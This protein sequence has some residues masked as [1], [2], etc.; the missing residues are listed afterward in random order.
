MS[1]NNEN[2]QIENAL[3]EDI[4]VEASAPAEEQTQVEELPTIEPAKVEEI[5]PEP[6]KV[7]SAPAKT[8]VIYS[9]KDL[10]VPGIGSIK[11]GYNE[12]SQK[13][14]EKWLTK[15][16]VRLAKAEEINLYL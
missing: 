10:T 8:V 15:N 13:D 4:K 14:A 16:S 5:K 7:P 1:E 9:L 12:V 11:K 3:V 2:V 6:I